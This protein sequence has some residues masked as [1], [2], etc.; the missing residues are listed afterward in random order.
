MLAAWATPSDYSTLLGSLSFS[1]LLLPSPTLYQTCYLY[2][3]PSLPPMTWV[4]ICAS[5]CTCC[6]TLKCHTLYIALW[7]RIHNTCPIHLIVCCVTHTTSLQII[8]S[9]S[10]DIPKCM[11]SSLP[12]SDYCYPWSYSSKITHLYLLYCSLPPCL[13]FSLSS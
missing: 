6:R 13:Q 2:A 8:L 9:A 12:I 10:S 4:A 7:W 5:E 1:H 3:A 11:E